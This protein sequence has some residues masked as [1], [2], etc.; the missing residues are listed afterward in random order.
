MT[1]EILRCKC[2]RI[3]GTVDGD[4]ATIKWKGR[5]IVVSRAESIRIVC[6][7]CKTETKIVAAECK[8]S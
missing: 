3:V 8:K 7:R 1:G 6:E 5:R 4:T 2:G